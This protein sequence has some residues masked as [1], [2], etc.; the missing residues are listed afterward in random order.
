MVARRR[1]EI[2]VPALEEEQIGE[3]PDQPQQ[4]EG[5]EGA[6]DTDADRQ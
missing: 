6:G 4:S 3:E 1:D 2:G 5:D